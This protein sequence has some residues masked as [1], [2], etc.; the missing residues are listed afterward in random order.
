MP[1]IGGG[2]NQW[3]PARTE[4]MPT[5]W[6]VFELR[7][8]APISLNLRDDAGYGSIVTA[9]STGA[10]GPTS[11]RMVGRSRTGKEP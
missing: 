3:I 8:H 2:R 10:A 11:G 5:G 7:F 6:V 9:T 4:V 1:G